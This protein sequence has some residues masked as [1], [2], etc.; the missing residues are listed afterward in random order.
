M[1]MLSMTLVRHQINIGV[2]L[3]VRVGYIILPVCQRQ[4]VEYVNP[5]SAK[6]DYGI[7]ISRVIRLIC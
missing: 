4:N 7:S 3:R 2:T 6:H 1:P 5:L